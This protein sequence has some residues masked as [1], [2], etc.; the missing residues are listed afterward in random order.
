MKSLRRISVL[1]AIALSS[2]GLAVGAGPAAA[3]HVSCGQTI[4][5]NTTLDANIGPCSRGLDIAANN[6]T[7]DLNGFTITGTPAAED[8]AG[9]SVSDRT[10]V[11]VKNGSITQ[12]DAGVG[13]SGGSGNTVTGMNLFANR[14]TRATEF[15]EGVNLFNTT[16]N[17]VSYNRITNNGPY[18]GIS[19]IRSSNNLIEHNQIARNNQDPFNTIGIRLESVGAA[20]SNNNTVRYNLIQ[21]SA[22][23]GI[24]LFP[25]ASD[26]VLSHNSLMQNA[27]DGIHLGLRTTRNIVEDSQARYNGFGQFPGRGIFLR[28]PTATVAGAFNNVI[29]RNI[30]T[31][32]RV[33][34]LLDG[35]PN[36][37]GNVWS[38]NQANTGEPACVF[39]P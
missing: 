14:G 36:C 16:G 39:N 3:G 8:N 6:V 5:Q 15:G 25:G 7:L 26:N 20:S 4:T 2:A 12:F 28:G 33:L 35:N 23:D 22:V 18:A 19:L 31:N 17:T 34:D 13:I 9:V 21:G 32:N 29:R 1:S 37:D 38:A 24:Q 27:R 10:G 30:A 11:T